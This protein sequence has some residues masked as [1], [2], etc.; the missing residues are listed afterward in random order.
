MM[1]YALQFFNNYVP[2][3]NYVWG[4]SFVKMYGRG[5]MSFLTYIYT[6]IK[7]NKKLYFIDSPEREGGEGVCQ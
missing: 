6:F 5:M 7:V 3:S 2:S 1:G 4:G